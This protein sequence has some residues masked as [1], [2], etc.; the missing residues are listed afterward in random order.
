MLST[1]G[2]SQIGAVLLAAGESSRFGDRNKLLVEIDGVPIVR[3][4]AKTLC[5]GNVGSVT[6]IIGHE[7]EAVK[8]CLADL[9]VTF[10]TNPEYAAGQ[11]T[12]VRAGVFEAKEQEWE[13][14]IF[15]L[16][17]MPF[18]SPASIEALIEAYK[19]RA[20]SIVAAAYN[21]TRGNPVLF[22]RKHYST[23]VKVTGDFGGRMLVKNHPES[24]LVETGDSGVIR[25]VDREGDLQTE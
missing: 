12:S 6:V 5:E 2:G 13:A 15:A 18:I 20:G 22:D 14:T 11:S 4:A 17:D 25:D 9:P 23:L 19:D 16:G 7:A 21:D 3:H 24:V 10:R 1:D 8:E